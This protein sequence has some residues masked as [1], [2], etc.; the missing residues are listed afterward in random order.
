M[1]KFFKSA[2]AA[3]TA[4]LATAVVISSCN[5]KFDNPPVYE[6]PAITANTTIADLKALF[7][8]SGSVTEITDDKVIKGIVIGD[9]K[10]GNLYQ[11]LVIQDETGGILIRM[12]GNEL[13]TSY[14]IGQEIFIK[15]KGLAISDYNKLVQLGVTNATGDGVDRIPS[16]L[17]ETYVVKGSPNNTV[18]AKEVTVADLTTDL[19][20]Q[21]QNTLIKLVGFEFGTSDTSKIYAQPST[22]SSG[23][24]FTIKN[25][26]GNSITLRNSAFADFAPF[27]IPNG[28]GDITAIYTV[29]GNTK[30]LTIR[31]TS[32]VQFNGTRC[33]SGGGGG[34]TGPIMRLSALRAMYTG[35]DIKITSS[36]RITGIVIS[37][38]AGKNINKSSVII[39]DG[40]SGINVFFGSAV[41]VD[42]NIGDSVVIDIT[43]DSLIKFRGSLE[44][45]A[46][47]AHF[48]PAVATGKVVTP[49]TVTISELNTA[50]DKPLGD[51]AN[52]EYTLIKVLSATASGIATYKGSATLTDASGNIVLFTNSGATFSGDALPSGAKNWTGYGY[53]FN[54]TKEISIRNPALD[55][56]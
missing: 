3:I 8:T 27:N 29:F 37:D 33:T 42:Y 46:L 18:T 34:G 31:D 6:A 49:K 40:N 16:A 53:F 22:V 32:D 9:D 55:V 1:N 45:K 17:F 10:S 20:D 13:Y 48:V 5:K 39:Q 35:S 28:N 30:Q 41:T 12:G 19:H 15:C 23:T 14:P 54:T 36:T 38:A 4:I 25:C 21:Y 56:Q 26:D 7:T 47:S 52:I 11:S 43:G 50:L 51:P 24:N 44:V 2:F